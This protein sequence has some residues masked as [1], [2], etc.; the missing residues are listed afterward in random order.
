M[1]RIY[2]PIIHIFFV[3][4]RHDFHRLFEM[5]NDMLNFQRSR[6]FQRTSNAIDP[7][8]WFAKRYL[9]GREIRWRVFMIRLYI[10]FL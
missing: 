2:D 7:Y 3:K 10:F 5:E 6:V 9:E 1:A 8:N 4:I